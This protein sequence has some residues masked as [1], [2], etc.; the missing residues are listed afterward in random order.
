MNSFPN[1]YGNATVA[2]SLRRMIDQDRIPQ[3]L[4][5]AGPEGVGKATLARRF[6]AVLLGDEAKIEQDDLSRPENVEM[7]AEREKL[8]SDKRAEEPLLLSSHPDFVTF[9]PDGPLRQISI[10]QMRLL[11]E[12][13]QYTPSR[14]KYRVFLI[15]RLDKANEQAA[16]SLLKT[17][18]EPP[19]H[20]VLIST[21]ENFYD[22]LPTI[23][24]RSVIFHLC[25]LSE[26]DMAAYA[27]SRGWKAGDRRVQLACGSPGVASSMDLDEWDK[28]RGRML[29]LLDAASGQAHFSAWVKHSE[30][31]SASKSEKLDYY[32]RI[33]YS[34]LED[35]LLMREGCAPSR[36][37]DLQ[38]QLQRVAGAV[39]F[40]WIRKF[41]AKL[42]ELVEFSRRN[43]QKG[44]ALDALAVELR[45]SNF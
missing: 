32:I 36:N 2:A 42:D 13:A 5:L 24:S 41:T 37:P 11:K 31:I 14:G 33:L 22:L 25:T 10:Q 16:N 43:V 18:E 34:L 3:T 40:D 38:S 12:R 4:L 29:A 26:E 19:E 15:D 1:F 7:L 23:R 9:P 6:A 45:R 28:R 30:A 8:Q 35:V 17:M 44:I 39:S 21:A 20:L 27:A